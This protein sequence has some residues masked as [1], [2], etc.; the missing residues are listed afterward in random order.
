MEEDYDNYFFK[1]KA[2][3]SCPAGCDHLWVISE[4]PYA[5]TYGEGFELSGA[6]DFGPRIGN[7]DLGLA[8]RC[9]TLCDEYSID[10]FEVSS[11]IAFA[12]ECFQRGILTE[13]DTGGLKL[14]W[15]SPDAILELI[16]M[17]AHREGIGDILSQG[18]PRA[19]KI[20][21]KGS[22]K[23]AMHVKGVSLVM[24]NVRAEKGWG[25][26][27]A[28]ASRGAC[29]VTAHP[30]TSYTEEHWDSAIKPILSKYKDPMN[31]LTEEGKA[32][33]IKWYEDLHAFK[34]AMEICIW[35]HY[36]WMGPAPTML[37]EFYNS[38]V[39]KDI[40]GDDLLHTGERIANVERAFNLTQGLTRKDDTLPDRMVKEPL[41]DGPAKG[42]VINIEPMVSEYYELRG[43]DRDSGFPTQKKLAELGLEDIADDLKKIGKLAKS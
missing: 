30:P 17:I 14:E 18:L 16:E 4:G 6:G 5:G 38:V 35:S 37:A 9:A 41:P 25:L 28:V 34:N 3:F 10:Y 19:T 8:C 11:A 31:P 7:S 40:S 15:G 12:M 42:Q 27:Y 39:G 43:W 22:E 13:K 36:A 26:G 32:D 29:H 24:R 1:N 33:I 2:C 23:Y 21:G 20:I